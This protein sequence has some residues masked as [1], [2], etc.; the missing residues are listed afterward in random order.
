MFYFFKFPIVI[1]NK[2]LVLCK[3]GSHG[4]G[5][6]KQFEAHLVRTTLPLKSTGILTTLQIA[7]KL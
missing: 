2:T 1:L 6:N 3:R 5:R 7:H 4:R